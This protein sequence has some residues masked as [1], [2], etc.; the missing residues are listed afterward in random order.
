MI[1]HRPL[2][3]LLLL[4]LPFI[5]LRFRRI[6]NISRA[7]LI[8]KG[9]VFAVL[10][11]ALADPWAQMLTQRLAITVLIDT[12]ASMPRQS[13]ES[14]QALLRDLV[15][16]N[17]GAELRLITFAEHPHFQDLPKDANKVTISQA[18]DPTES[19]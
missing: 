10:V 15:R 5:W 6:A 4:A 8:L 12:S 16:K 7:S 18:L 9:V 13:I 3:L 11:I 1:F 2:F 17:S 19:M 14:G